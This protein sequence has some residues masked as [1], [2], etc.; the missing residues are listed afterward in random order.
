MKFNLERRVDLDCPYMNLTWN[1]QYVSNDFNEI[2]S[3]HN[4]ASLTMRLAITSC[5]ID[6]G[7]GEIG[8]IFKD[9]S[10][11]AQRSNPHHNLN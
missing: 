7:N 8:C 11:R 6:I 1:I 9:R 4:F 2:A 3:S 5:L 10:L